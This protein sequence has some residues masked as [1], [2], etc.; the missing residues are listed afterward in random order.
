MGRDWSWVVDKAD[1]KMRSRVAS[2][3][4]VCIY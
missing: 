2:K 1:W 3:D 4:S